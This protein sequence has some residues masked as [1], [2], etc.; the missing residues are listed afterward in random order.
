MSLAFFILFLVLS[1]FLVL[2]IF[3]FSTYHAYFAK[4]LPFLIG[5]AVAVGYA[6]FAIKSFHPFWITQI[7]G[8]VILFLLAWRYQTKRAKELIEQ[9]MDSQE[10]HNIASLSMQSTKAYFWL[11]VVVYLL[12]YSIAFITLLNILGVQRNLN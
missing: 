8:S 3:R 9:T 7:W 1:F 2:Q 6:V 4:S 11:S 12:S 10:Q 5:Y